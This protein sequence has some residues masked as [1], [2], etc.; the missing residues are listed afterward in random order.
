M[1][2]GR[3][4]GEVDLIWGLVFFRSPRICTSRYSRRR[5][6]ANWGTQLDRWLHGWPED[7]PKFSCLGLRIRRIRD[8]DALKSEITEKCSLHVAQLKGGRLGC[9]SSGSRDQVFPF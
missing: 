2:L 3:R 9:V 6:Y 1:S 5:G 4:V 8:G 7:L